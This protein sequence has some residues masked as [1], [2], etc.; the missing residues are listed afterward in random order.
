MLDIE[1]L[2]LEPG[3]VI[4]SIGAV[5]FDI[6]GLGETF[7]RSIN[8]ESCADAGLEI[9]AETLEWWLDQD[10][11]VRGVLTGGEDLTAVLSEFTDWFLDLDADEV[12]ANSPT[13]DCRVLEH[14]YGAV[15]LDAPWQFYQE[16]D[17]R[18]LKKL[19][20]AVMADRDGDKHDALDDAVHQADCAHLTLR[21]M[22]DL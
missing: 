5:A 22:V 4:L 8:L 16:R 17:F 6:D 21:R 14:A 18:T 11:A 10:D 15:G 20:V 3:C 7:H 2:G 1:T 9:D 13:F 19:P 12:W